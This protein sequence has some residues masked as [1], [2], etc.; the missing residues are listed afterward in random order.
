MC[1]GE[2]DISC[3]SVHCLTAKTLHTRAKYLPLISS[4]LTGL[5]AAQSPQIREQAKLLTTNH[6]GQPIEDVLQL[7]P[8]ESATTRLWRL[9]TTRTKLPTKRT[10]NGHGD[11][12]ETCQVLDITKQNAESRS[13][14][15]ADLDVLGSHAT[16]Q[17]PCSIGSR[18]MQWDTDSWS[19]GS[20]TSALSQ[21]EYDAEMDREEHDECWEDSWADSWSNDTKSQPRDGVHMESHLE[22]NPEAPGGTS[23]WNPSAGPQ[24]NDKE[25]HAFFQGSSLHWLEHHKT[26]PEVSQVQSENSWRCMEAWSADDDEMSWLAS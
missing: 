4:T 13:F 20:S 19:E 1:Q 18:T 14:A 10:H 3:T 5:S 12:V 24:H 2:R 25:S 16:T 15:K 9:I 23:P 11:A 6:T 26:G 7:L 21:R 17:S 22:R 8:E